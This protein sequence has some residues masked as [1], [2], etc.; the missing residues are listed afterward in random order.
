M[1]IEPRHVT[2]V[3]AS[4]RRIAMTEDEEGEIP[5]HHR[6][7]IEEGT[8][9]QRIPLTALLRE[10]LETDLFQVPALARPRPGQSFR[11]DEDLQTSIPDH[12]RLLPR[13]L[14]LVDHLPAGQKD[15]RATIDLLHYHRL[16]DQE[17]DGTV[18]ATQKKTTPE[19]HRKGHQKAV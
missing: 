15:Q 3:D 13:V 9:L 2:Q 19:G 17:S 12:L 4:T 10:D 7:L 14:L 5:T 18:T 16:G 1:T 8:D 11:E 6:R